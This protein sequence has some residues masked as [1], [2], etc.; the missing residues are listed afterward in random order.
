MRNLV[1]LVIPGS[2]HYVCF[3]YTTQDDGLGF[4]PVIQSSDLEQVLQGTF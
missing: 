1:V 4:T 2:H 3:Y